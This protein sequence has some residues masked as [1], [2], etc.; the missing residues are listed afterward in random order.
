MRNKTKKNT[1]CTTV[2][3]AKLELWYDNIEMLAIFY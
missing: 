1:T 2:K 3:C